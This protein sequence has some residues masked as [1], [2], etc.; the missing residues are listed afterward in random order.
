MKENDNDMTMEMS[1]DYYNNDYDDVSQNIANDYQDDS[2]D[3]M[4]NKFGY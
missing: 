1:N 2:D 3:E 4:A